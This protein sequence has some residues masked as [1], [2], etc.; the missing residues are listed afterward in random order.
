VPTVSQSLQAAYAG[1]R[2]R[3]ARGVPVTYLQ[4]GSESTFLLAGTDES[5]ALVVEL[6]LGSKRTARRFFAHAPPTGAELE[7]AIAWIEEELMRADRRIRGSG[8]VF[9]GAE[10]LRDILRFAGVAAQPQASLDVETVE[11]TFNR[12]AAVALG[13]PSAREGVPS[14][15]SFAATL[16]IL[17]EL[18]HHL[19]YGR[20]VVLG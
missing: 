11:R 19:Q 6:S 4:I 12:L 3:V 8:Q 15:A 16:L 13:R 7:R 5:P 2:A 10:A 17:R 1:A 20:I 9:T 14:S 18:M